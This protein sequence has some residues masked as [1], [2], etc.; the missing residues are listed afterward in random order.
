MNIQQYVLNIWQ[1]VKHFG[2]HLH[3]NKR[4]IHVRTSPLE[5][6]WTWNRLKTI[7]FTKHLAK[8]QKRSPFLSITKLLLSFM[9]FDQFCF[10]SFDTFIIVESV[11]SHSREDENWDCKWAIGIWLLLLK[12]RRT[13]KAGTITMNKSGLNLIH[14]FVRFFAVHF[15][16]LKREMFINTFLNLRTYKSV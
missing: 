2:K 11:T 14:F 16:K 1:K 10:K 15:C 9:Y 12:K 7:N 5:V 6:I 4:T 13:F 3:L 8:S